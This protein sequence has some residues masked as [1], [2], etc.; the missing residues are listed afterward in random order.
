[1][2]IGTVSNVRHRPHDD[3]DDDDDTDAH[4]TALCRLVFKTSS[5]TTHI[6]LRLSFGLQLVVDNEN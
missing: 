2:T 6:S 1:M 4:P 5:D 3:D